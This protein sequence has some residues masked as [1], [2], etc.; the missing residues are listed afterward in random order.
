LDFE[1]VLPVPPTTAFPLCVLVGLDLLGLWA[2]LTLALLFV[3]PVWGRGA[4]ACFALFVVV[5]AR[6]A[7]GWSC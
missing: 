1:R 4:L 3:G 5:R 6:E 7:S 2:D